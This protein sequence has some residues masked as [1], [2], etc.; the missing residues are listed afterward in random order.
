M[1]QPI[2]LP[3]ADMVIGDSFF[4][5]CLDDAEIK[6]EATKLAKQFAVD[7][8]VEKVVYNGMYGIRIWRI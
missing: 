1:D 8:R 2:E 4:V 7:L 5:P 3:I 6:R